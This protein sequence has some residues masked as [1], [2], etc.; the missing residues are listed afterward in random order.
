MRY[1]TCSNLFAVILHT[2][3]TFLC[4]FSMG[5]YSGKIILFLY[6]FPKS[7]L[8][9]ILF[10]FIAN[11]KS[12]QALGAERTL[13]SKLFFLKKSIMEHE[14]LFDLMLIPCKIFLLR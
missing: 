4:H 13:K 12:K 5:I 14:F 1:G 8:F 10:H 7:P 11:L 2:P 6:Y 9:K 3:P